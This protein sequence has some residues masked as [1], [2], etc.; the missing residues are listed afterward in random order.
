MEFS[1]LDFFFA[2]HRSLHAPPAS[3]GSS[4]LQAVCGSLTDAQYRQR[5]EGHSSIAFLL[6]HIGRW[7][8]AIVNLALHAEP[9]VLDRDGWLPRLGVDTRD[10]GVGRRPE[11]VDAFSARVDIDALHAYRAAVAQQTRASMGLADFADLEEV[12]PGAAER[13]YGSG[14]LTPETY[15]E[16]PRRQR[17]WFVGFGLLGHSF[18]HLGEAEVVARLLGRPGGV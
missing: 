16:L 6:W 7:E 8:D 1:G 12:I 15:P 4:F 14:V 9:E 17:R 10:A 11:E 5:P 13:M 3:G 2:V 18:A